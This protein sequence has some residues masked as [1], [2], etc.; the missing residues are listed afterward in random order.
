M[1]DIFQLEKNP[2]NFISFNK[3]P[4]LNL[5]LYLDNMNENF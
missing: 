5:Y 3:D 4:G 2:D 1:K